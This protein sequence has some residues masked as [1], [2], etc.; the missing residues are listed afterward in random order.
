MCHQVGLVMETTLP[1]K[2]LRVAL[3]YEGWGC[4]SSRMSF[5]LF[6]AKKF[7]IQDPDINIIYL[8]HVL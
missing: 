3:G 8:T 7:T 4:T 5:P 2:R 6:I 1:E